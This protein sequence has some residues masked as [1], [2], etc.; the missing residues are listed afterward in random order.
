M[1]GVAEPEEQKGVP[2]Y[3]S[4]DGEGREEDGFGDKSK[5]PEV[6]QRQL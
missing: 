2:G 5:G 1:A 6:G 3:D 4:R